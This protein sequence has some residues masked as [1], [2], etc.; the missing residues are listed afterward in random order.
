MDAASLALKRR[1]QAEEEETG[2]T[3]ESPT[4]IRVGVMTT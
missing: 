1:G 2:D 4:L 3:E